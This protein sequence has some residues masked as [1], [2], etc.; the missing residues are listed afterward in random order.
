MI[1]DDIRDIKLTKTECKPKVIALY[2]DSIYRNM[3]DRKIA[4]EMSRILT[5]DYLE[6]EMINE[7]KNSIQLT[8]NQ[9][10]DLKTSWFYNQSTYQEAFDECVRIYCR[11]NSNIIFTSDMGIEYPVEISHLDGRRNR[12]IDGSITRSPYGKSSFKINPLDLLIVT[13][14]KQY[15]YFGMGI[16]WVHDVRRIV[17]QSIFKDCMFY[18]N[19]ESSEN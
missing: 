18:E 12:N 14:I 2:L 4:H 7:V 3:N 19:Y 6:D 9:I 1:I 13:C 5:E 17:Y 16:E 11:F 10:Y 8:I 15:D